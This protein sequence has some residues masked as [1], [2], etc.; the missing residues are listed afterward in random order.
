[1]P[2]PK[3]RPTN[4]RVRAAGVGD[5]GGVERREV[6]KI[7]P[8]RHP[9]RASC[10]DVDEGLVVTTQDGGGH[11]VWA[12]ARARG[13]GQGEGCELEMG[14]GLER[15]VGGG[16]SEISAALLATPVGGEHGEH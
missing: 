9:V 13:F 1:M 2:V 16:R 12:R 4:T 10:G 11:L 7:S 3:V 8:L 15:G 6:G 5:F 14:T